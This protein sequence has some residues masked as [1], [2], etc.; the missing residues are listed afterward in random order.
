MWSVLE[1]TVSENQTHEYAQHG[2]VTFFAGDKKFL[3]ICRM[4]FFFQWSHERLKPIGLE[5]NILLKRA[6]TVH[7]LGALSPMTSHGSN[8]GAAWDC[9]VSPDWE[10][11]AR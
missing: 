3:L 5:V 1:N 8:F 10:L 11:R 9:L 4:C 2:R 6:V 7:N